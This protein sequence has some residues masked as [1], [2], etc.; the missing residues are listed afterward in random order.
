[1]FGWL[2]R[3]H[4]PEPADSRQLADPVLSAEER[5]DALLSSY[6]DGDLTVSEREDVTARLAADGDLRAALDGMRL[7]RDTLGRFETVRAPRTFAIT[8]PP[9]RERRSG[10]RR[11]DLVARFG[12]MAASVAFVAVLAGD[13]SGGSTPTGTIEEQFSS[14]TADL[15]ADAGAGS[16]GAEFAT[17]TLPPDGEGDEVLGGD[18]N[19]VSGSGVA[20]ADQP[21]QATGD[22]AVTDAP[23]TERAADA[24]PVG[25]DDAPV[26]AEAASAEL[27]STQEPTPLDADAATNAAAVDA[28]TEPEGDA[29]SG[30]VAPST[31]QGPVEVVD[32][33][34]EAPAPQPGAATADPPGASA[35]DEPSAPSAPV[36]PP[37][38]VPEAGDGDDSARGDDDD[39]AGTKAAEPALGAQTGETST[40]SA[41]AEDVNSLIEGD[42][43]V[44]G[45]T[46]ALGTVAASLAAVSV[47]FWWRRRGGMTGPV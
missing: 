42:R 6:L 32:D 17:E 40:L 3:K 19:P 12:A 21:P 38:V 14:T 1:M 36:S 43:E 46:I 27:N 11:L 39:G 7:V 31:A 25:D 28:G 23:T 33:P 37:G 9:V 22:D 8:A 10:Y 29:G 26:E 41:N 16:D 5:R 47:L 24:D 2:R 13:L 44:S 18:V 15:A 20:D 34:A 4:P 45:L 30:D 35:V